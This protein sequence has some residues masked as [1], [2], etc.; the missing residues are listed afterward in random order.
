MMTD[1]FSK[2]KY[3]L[4]EPLHTNKSFEGME[5][6]IGN[7]EGSTITANSRWIAVSSFLI[8]ISSKDAMACRR[9]RSHY[10]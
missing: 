2:Y 10:G 6:P 4:G 5:L 9:R 3:I 1:K 7:I 8:F